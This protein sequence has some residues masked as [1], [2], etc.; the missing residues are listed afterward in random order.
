M[1]IGF[2]KLND[3]T[4]YFPQAAISALNSLQSNSAIVK[5]FNKPETRHALNLRSLPETVEWLRRIGYKVCASLA[6][7]L[8]AIDR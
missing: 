6:I 8:F 1:E 7:E 2:S 3:R 4:D 5:E